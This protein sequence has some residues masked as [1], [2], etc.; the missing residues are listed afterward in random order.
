M[1]FYGIGG[2]PILEEVNVAE[3]SP[4]TNS[5][6]DGPPIPHRYCDY[7]WLPNSFISILQYFICI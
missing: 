6:I 1:G 2:L 4:V 5:G 3:L 7:Q